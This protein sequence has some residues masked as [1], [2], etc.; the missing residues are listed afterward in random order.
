ADERDELFSQLL[1]ISAEQFYVIGTVLPTG[2]YGIVKDTFHNVPAHLL[3][4]WVYPLPGPTS[5]EQY[6]VRT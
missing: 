4:G 2:A 5:P 3:Y 6:A 1:A